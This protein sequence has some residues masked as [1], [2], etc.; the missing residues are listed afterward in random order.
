MDSSGVMRKIIYRERPMGSSG[1]CYKIDPAT[2]ERLLDPTTGQPIT[3]KA[4]HI[5][6]GSR[7]PR[8]TREARRKEISANEIERINIGV[9]MRRNAPKFEEV[10]IQ[11]IDVE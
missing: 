8:K 3:V 11:K 4:T 10:T 9:E 7:T 6:H 1:P 2:G 5:R